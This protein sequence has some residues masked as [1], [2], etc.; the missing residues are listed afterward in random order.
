MELISAANFSEGTDAGV[1]ASI[2]AAARE[3]GAKVLD[4]HA[5]PD[6]DRSVITLSAPPGSLAPATLAAAREGVARIDLRTHAGAHPRIG[7]IDVAPVVYAEQALRGAA[8]AEALVLAD[9]LGAEL[10]LPVFL[11]GALAGGRTRA[12]LR[13]GGPAELERRLASGELAPD[14]GPARLHPSAGAVL[15][16]AR[17]PLVA[18]NVE[19]APPATVADAS[20]IAAAIRD[21]GSEGLTGVRALGIELASR[22]VAQVSTNVEDA[23]TRLG[24]VVS[25]VARQAPVA[26]AEVVG[27]VPA[28]ALDGF[29][30]D[31]P[32]RGFDPSR[33]VLENALS[34]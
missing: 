21:G 29:P 7:A 12:E 10:E 27:L 4:T 31:V 32:I 17:P 16:A 11:Y 13:Y 2:A 22:G 18:F 1:V 34:S 28:S 19:L 20:R 23:T 33:Q 3:T 24:A 25:A 6:H 5:D 30:D 15:V 14:F 9:M 26:A 8:C